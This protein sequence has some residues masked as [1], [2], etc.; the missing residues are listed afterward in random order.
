M[1]LDET[2]SLYE[3][4]ATWPKINPRD[5]TLPGIKRYIMPSTYSNGYSAVK[6]NMASRET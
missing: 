1:S 5:F 3:T 6:T 4:M 2:I